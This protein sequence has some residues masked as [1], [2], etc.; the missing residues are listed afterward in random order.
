MS[1]KGDQS[2]F[3]KIDDDQEP[4][5]SSL[6]LGGPE[7]KRSEDSMVSHSGFMKE[8][9]THLEGSSLE[10]IV[11]QARTSKKIIEVDTKKKEEELLKE[12]QHYRDR[13]I[14]EEQQDYE[15]IVKKKKEIEGKKNKTKSDIE[16]SKND[17]VRKFLERKKAL[18][19]S[20]SNLNH[21]EAVE[22]INV[23]AKL[24][25]EVKKI[26]EDMASK[27]KAKLE[28]LENW[29]KEHHKTESESI[30]KSEQA[31]RQ[32]LLNSKDAIQNLRK[33]NDIQRT[34][35]QESNQ[36]ENLALDKEY[37]S[38]ELKHMEEVKQVFEKEKSIIEKYNRLR[39]FINELGMNNDSK[40]QPIIASPFKNSFFN[41][42]SRFDTSRVAEVNA[43][44]DKFNRQ[45]MELEK[46]KS[47]LEKVNNEKQTA[48]GVAAKTEK[49]NVELKGSI[50]T[51]EKQVIELQA[52][53]KTLRGE[54]E[55]TKKCFEDSQNK[56]M[57]FIESNMKQQPNA[58]QRG[59]SFSRG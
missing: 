1:T 15:S 12:Y 38:F 34:K 43:L 54:Q 29:V 55:R 31:H 41:C 45:Q 18:D 21:R 37:E 27:K 36:K 3:L 59:N 51:L 22:E 44:E 56:F 14:K 2:S 19:E 48:E 46:M 17:E 57:A 10:D 30:N 58:N 11:D 5:N 52:S 47:Q 4:E 53:L 8:I 33:E 28:E 40:F 39:T 26:R 35:L 20:D 9:S 42:L 6:E 13:F 24:E 23:R 49:N 50:S 7:T 25:A 16:K 32:E